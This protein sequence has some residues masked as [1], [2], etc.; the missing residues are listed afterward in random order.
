MGKK[1]KPKKKKFE[2]VLE[3]FKLFDFPNKMSVNMRAFY[4]AI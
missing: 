1:T 2:K 3:L 4:M